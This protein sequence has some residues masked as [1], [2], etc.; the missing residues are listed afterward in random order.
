MK[1]VTVLLGTSRKGS[2]YNATQ[3]FMQFVQAH[4]EVTVDYVALPDFDL[5]Y[6]T[7]CKLCFDKDESKCPLKD[8]RDLLIDKLVKSDGVIFASPNYAFHVTACM[9]NFFDRTAFYFHRPR[10]FNKTCTAI[11]SQGIFN[12]AKIVKYLNDSGENLG[13]NAVKGVVVN[14]LEPTTEKVQLQNKAAIKKAADRFY[15]DLS[16]SPVKRPSFFRLM[17]FRMSRSSIERM[18]N[19]DFKDYRYFKEQGWFESD[20][21]YAVKLGL[22]KSIFGRLF[23][24]MGRQMAKQMQR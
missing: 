9:K 17:M 12:G 20:Y 4:E 19:E 1:H 10:F 15:R 23:D 18:L 21:Y 2:T 5:K 24:G 6:C 22:V 16:Q 7:G 11:V 13:F 8:D 3:T 14:G